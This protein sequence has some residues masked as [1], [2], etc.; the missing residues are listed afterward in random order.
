M[1]GGEAEARAKGGNVVMEIGGFGFEW[2]AD[3]GL[4]GRADGGVGG[5]GQDRD[6]DERLVKW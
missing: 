1:S 5:Y 6:C 4:E 3:V 2:Y